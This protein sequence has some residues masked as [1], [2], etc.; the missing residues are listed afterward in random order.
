MS[1]PVQHSRE[2]APNLPVQ[3]RPKRA[4]IRRV[5]LEEARARRA[6][7]N[8]RREFVCT[9]SQVWEHRGDVR[10]LVCDQ[11]A[12]VSQNRHTGTLGVLLPNGTSV[13]MPVAALRDD[14]LIAQFAAYNLLDMP[15]PHLARAWVQVVV[16][17]LA[18][19]A[20]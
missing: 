6:P 2:G 20:D 14:D 7:S 17:A 1:E 11:F 10:K 12:I 5:P 18:D 15:K 13:D 19:D 8:G 16:A 4:Y 9:G 3:P